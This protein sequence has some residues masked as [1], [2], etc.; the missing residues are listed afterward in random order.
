MD[1]D[2]VT[3]DNLEGAIAM[4]SAERASENFLESWIPDGYTANIP[5]DS[6]VA[7]WKS[8][9]KRDSAK[10]PEYQLIS[11]TSC[12]ITGKG[13]NFDNGDIWFRLSYID[14]DGN[15][16]DKLIKKDEMF[17]RG[18]LYGV[19]GNEKFIVTEKK[20]GDL[21]EY[22]TTCL[23]EN[24][25]YLEDVFV[26]NSN[27]WK[28]G[29]SCFVFG[30]KMYSDNGMTDIIIPDEDMSKGLGK[31]GTVEDWVAANEQLLAYPH[32]RFVC[33]S[34]MASILIRL[35]G[36]QS[37][38]VDMYGESTTGKSTTCSIAMS[39]I[40]NTNKLMI[41]ADSTPT[42]IEYLAEIYSDLP[43]YMDETSNSDVE[44]LQRIIYMISNEKGKSRGQKDGGLRETS[45]WKC[46][47]ITN[48]ERPITS[49]EGLTGQKVRVIEIHGGIGANDIG[50]LVDN[51]KRSNS[52]ASYGH[53]IEPFLEKLFE[54][55]DDLINCFSQY[56]T[57]FQKTIENTNN[58]FIDYFAAMTVAGRLVEEVYESI[59]I[60]S[61]D[62]FEITNQVYD[63]SVLNNPIEK[64][65]IIMLREIIEWISAQ[66]AHFMVDIRQKGQ[67]PKK[68]PNK[69]SPLYGWHSTNADGDEVV[70]IIPRI[71][72]K[73][74]LANKVG[75]QQVLK[76]E[77]KELG[78]LE[79][80][81]KEYNKTVQHIE[82]SN[83]N[84]TK[85]T[86][87]IRLN[88]VK[89]NQILGLEKEEG[90]W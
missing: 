24:Y 74:F 27:G 70:D 79:T 75:D 13:V 52:N 39:Q 1:I 51:S 46:I 12:A 9:G 31:K 43:L 71:F 30:S 49:H 10:G 16:A 5:T 63:E 38:I 32:V 17:T 45:S 66:N 11:R 55:K 34:A 68:A 54:N 72:N 61:V 36:V 83:Q 26:A 56:Q 14:L 35:L 29:D 76:R 85:A 73:D 90:N 53:I 62:P 48:G 4:E 64:H 84:K 33:Y 7:I 18:K 86:L 78:V 25:L 77:W 23:D 21:I 57:Q 80:N 47:A 42:A 6:K 87:V 60:E 37:Y 19:L 59:G 22:L 67:K 81:K 89:V 41:N 58:R 65:S 82:N 20:I 3:A 15:R 8:F 2:N 40:G 50:N 69:L 88:M 28:K 44:I